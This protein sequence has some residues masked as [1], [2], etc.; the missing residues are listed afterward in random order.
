[1]CRLNITIFIPFLPEARFKYTLYFFINGTVKA[2]LV[3]LLVCTKNYD[4]IIHAQESPNLFTVQLQ[5]GKSHQ[6]TN[7]PGDQLQGPLKCQ[8]TVV[9]IYVITSYKVCLG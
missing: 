9:N 5:D 1:M 7:T 2:Q 8:S 3:Q 6:C 4:I